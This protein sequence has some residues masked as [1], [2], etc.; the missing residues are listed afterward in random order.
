MFSEIR[1]HLNTA[2]GVCV[3]CV[4]V[5]MT[6]DTSA[7]LIQSFKVYVINFHDFVGTC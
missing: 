2:V 4:C 1:Y 5:W 3:I 6:R 7:D